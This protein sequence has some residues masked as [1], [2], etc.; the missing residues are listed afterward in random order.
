MTDVLFQNKI[1]VL[2][3]YGIKMNPKISINISK[4]HIKKKSLLKTIIAPDKKHQMRIEIL[5]LRIILSLAK[6]R[7][8]LRK[9]RF[10]IKKKIKNHKKSLRVYSL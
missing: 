7:T 6:N 4:N 5:I 8:I 9:S 10:W 1:S 2:T 3:P